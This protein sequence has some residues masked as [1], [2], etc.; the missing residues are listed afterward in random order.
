MSNTVIKCLCGAC[1]VSVSASP[2]EQ[3]Y[4]HCDDCRAVSG[5]AYASLSLYPMGAVTLLNG[6]TVTWVYKSLPRTI[7]T[8]CGTILFGEVASLGVRGVNASLLPK[9]NFAP[10]FHQ[11]CKFAELPISDRLPHYV[12]S[13]AIWG[14]SDEQVVWTTS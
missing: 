6:P 5:G 4:C 13:P 2:L 12:G 9:P 11:Q 10:R 14:G 3:F 8:S 1:E 7:C